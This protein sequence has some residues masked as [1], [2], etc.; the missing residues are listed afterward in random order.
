M[1]C[2]AW[3]LAALL[4][5]GVGEEPP[6]FSWT[7]RIPKL[8]IL[9]IDLEAVAGR[10]EC[11]RGELAVRDL[12]ARLPG[13]RK[14]G[15]LTGKGG[16]RLGR[17]PGLRLEARVEGFD[18][19]AVKELPAGWPAYQFAGTARG[20]VTV[21]AL[22][23][24]ASLEVRGT[25]R[26]ADAAVEK[27]TLGTTDFRFVHRAGVLTLDRIQA[28]MGGGE[29]TGAA[30]LPLHEADEGSLDLAVKDVDAGPA[31]KALLGGALAVKGRLSGR[32]QGT[33]TGNIGP[34]HRSLRAAVDLTGKELRVRGIPTDRVRGTVRHGD[35]RTAYALEAEA[36]GVRVAVEGQVPPPRRK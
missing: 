21:E 32:V 1:A 19:R 26:V 34:Q 36:R 8:Q 6:A 25:V 24:L 30:V 27:L 10:L 13:P 28:R 4:S 2:L 17:R 16:L 7:F 23:G 12:T 35:G 29:L 11:R 20:D 18:L 5:P 14:P 9:G 3:I 31:V 22:R 15:T 33:I